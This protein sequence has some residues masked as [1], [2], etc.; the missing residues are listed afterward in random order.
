MATTPI[1]DKD[2]NLI[3]VL[4]HSL[5]GAD[6]CATYIQDAESSNDSE[7]ADFLKDAK[8]R[9]EEL[10]QKAKKLAASRIG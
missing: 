1:P 3:S 5:S 9:Y 7:L 2:Y 10:A 6:S 4:Y 8:S